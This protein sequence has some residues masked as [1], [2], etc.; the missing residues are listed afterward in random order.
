[1]AKVAQFGVAEVG[2][3]FVAEQLVAAK[4]EVVGRQSPEN[5]VVGMNFVVVVA[6]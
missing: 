3:H 1:M 4:E 6:D 5:A 2:W